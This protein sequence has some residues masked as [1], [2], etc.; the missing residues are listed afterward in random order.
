MPSTALP[1]H[2]CSLTSRTSGSL[3]LS[4]WHG[5]IFLNAFGVPAPGLNGLLAGLG[6]HGVELSPVEEWRWRLPGEAEA[7]RAM[8]WLLKHWPDV[9]RLELTLIAPTLPGECAFR[10]ELN[11]GDDVH[12]T[13]ELEFHRD[14]QR[15]RVPQTEAWLLELLDAPEYEA[16]SVWDA[17]WQVSR[18]GMTRLLHGPMDPFAGASMR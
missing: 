10:F 3:S 17:E 15:A 4:R 18:A 13:P 2:A 9:A 16:K 8:H 7:R 11:G 1:Q 12:L 6:E 5:A 14:Q